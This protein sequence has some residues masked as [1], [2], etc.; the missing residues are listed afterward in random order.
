MLLPSLFPLTAAKTNKAC[1]PSAAAQ[2]LVVVGER[3]CTFVAKSHHHL[4]H[5]VASAP[6][7]DLRSWLLKHHLSASLPT[8]RKGAS[9]LKRVNF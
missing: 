4:H 7:E 5:D 1:S 3:S 6:L 2:G 8:L 9:K